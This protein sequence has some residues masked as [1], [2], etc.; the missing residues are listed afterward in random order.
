MLQVRENDEPIYIYYGPRE[1][2]EHGHSLAQF[3]GC[4][5]P[6]HAMT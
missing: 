3:F 2:A 6:N 4:V 1:L 5:Q